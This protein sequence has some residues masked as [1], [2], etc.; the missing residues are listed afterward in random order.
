MCV[1]KRKPNGNRSALGT[2][3]SETTTMNTTYTEA[4]GT[5]YTEVTQD[6]PQKKTK[7]KSPIV[8]PKV[9]VP[10]P[11]VKKKDEPNDRTADESDERRQ[12]IIDA[13]AAAC[14]HNNFT[15][16]K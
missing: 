9:V 7:V 16:R 1:R 15:Q 11:A 2:E 5:T 3:M 8:S 6:E 10:K 13:A 12:K 14:R 4:G